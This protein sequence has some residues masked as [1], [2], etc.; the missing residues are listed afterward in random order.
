MAED[1]IAKA[2]ATAL[3][4]QAA[5]NDRKVAAAKVIADEQAKKITCGTVLGAGVAG[6]FPII[7]G[8]IGLVNI[9]QGRVAK[10]LLFWGMTA[11]WVFLAIL[12]SVASSN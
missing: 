9:I 8:I 4:L 1:D 11:G 6:A 3:A 7:G 2:V 12:I 10:G 5:E